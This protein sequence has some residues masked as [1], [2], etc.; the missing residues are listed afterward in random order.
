MR[1][2][3]KGEFSRGWTVL[4]A[5]LVATMCG[6][7]PVPFN[8]IG[9][10]L[11]PL[12]AE[13][14]WNPGQIMIGI[15]CYGLTGCIMAPI[16]GALADKYGARRVGLL[17]LIGFGL[18]FAGVGLVSSLPMF[19]V[20]YVLIGLL[21]VGSTPITWSRA[22]NLWFVQNRGLALGIMLLGTGVAGFILPSLTVYLINNAGWRW[23]YGVIALLPLLVALP[24]VI[25][26]MREPKPGEVPSA[27]AGASTKTGFTLSA[28]LRDKRFWIMIV[29]FTL[30][31]IAYG[32]FHTNLQNMIRL[33]GI[34]DGAGALI[35]GCVGLSIIVGRVGTGLLVDRF[36]AP[37]VALPLLSMPALAC[38][39]FITD[40][41]PLA[42]IV[43]AAVMLG[44][45]AGA[46]TDLIAYL[47]GRY[48]GM[49]YYGRIYGMLYA[50]FAGGSA[51]SPPLYGYVVSTHGNYTPILIASAVMFVAGAILLMLLG[52]YPT[53]FPAV[54][55]A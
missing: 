28:A 21:G 11:K 16:V 22:V 46:E 30:V 17:S 20:M 52:R 3:G 34:S 13:F 45:A 31:S 53:S 18:A 41:P 54:K 42:L 2:A 37:L 27:D 12:S 23:A 19:Y 38:G 33:K 15:M 36:W 7:S 44:F 29:S 48:F 51:I 24:I 43:L 9:S 4:L 14:G 1:D 25:A 6:A 8:T 50:A 40:A 39:I 26:F 47:A 10:F 35:A 55:P 49:A 5:A 32:G